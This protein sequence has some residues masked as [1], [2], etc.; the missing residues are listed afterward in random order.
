[1]TE[2][3][4]NQS[5]VK[6]KVVEVKEVKTIGEK[7]AKKLSFKAA[8]DGKE[9]WFFSWKPDLFPL[10]TAGAEIV[11]D[12]ETSQRDYDGNTYTDRKITQ[13]YSPDGAPL[14]AIK[15]PGG[16]G[17]GK[18]L[19]TVKSEGEYRLRERES[20]NRS[21]EFQVALKECGEC[22]REK[23][24]LPPALEALYYKNLEKLLTGQTLPSSPVI[25]NASS[26]SLVIQLPGNKESEAP[27]P[28][29]KKPKSIG[30][31]LN[32]A[33]G[34][35]ITKAQLMDCWGVKSLTEIVDLEA[36]W[37]KAKKAFGL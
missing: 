20:Q 12:I 34:K 19:E 10:I 30:E 33:K 31:I 4:K 9:V 2:P 25:V 15:G 18:S 28:E 36:A 29:T 13:I 23:Y 35:G 26:N 6:L 21:I 3:V 27:L 14:G 11:A 8:Q 16:F 17:G 37:E 24:P 32:L 5:K 22:L 1:M 7:G